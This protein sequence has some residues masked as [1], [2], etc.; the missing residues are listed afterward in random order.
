ML[1]LTEASMVTA[2]QRQQ[3]SARLFYL[4]LHLCPHL[5]IGQAMAPAT[6]ALAGRSR[7]KLAST[8]LFRTLLF[9]ANDASHQPRNVPVFSS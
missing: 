7:F 1:V 4:R 2:F 9:L 6:A 3:S 5:G 8:A